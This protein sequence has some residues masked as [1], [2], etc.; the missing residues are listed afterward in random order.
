M[1]P[2][3]RTRMEYV[4]A[5]TDIVLNTFDTRVLTRKPETRQLFFLLAD[6]YINL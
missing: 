1:D 3:R 5:K 2:N 6:R 4:M